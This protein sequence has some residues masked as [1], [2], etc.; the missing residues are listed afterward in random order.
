MGYPSGW[1]MD[2]LGSKIQAYYAGEK[3]WDDVIAES[4]AEWKSARQ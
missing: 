2:I 1:G 4:V 3:S